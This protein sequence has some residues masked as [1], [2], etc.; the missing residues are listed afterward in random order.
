MTEK[1]VLA[2]KGKPVSNMPVRESNMETWEY[3]DLT[4]GFEAGRVTQVV[5]SEALSFEA[6]TFPTGIPLRELAMK[7]GLDESRLPDPISS[8]ISR[9]I[10]IQGGTLHVGQSQGRVLTYGLQLS[11]KN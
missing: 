6:E 10:P 7:L 5:G 9:S 11:E 2:T 4:V 3:E 1:Q 8:P